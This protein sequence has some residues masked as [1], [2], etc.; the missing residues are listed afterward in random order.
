M[1]YDASIQMTKCQYY[2]V[3]TIIIAVNNKFYA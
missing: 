3:K 1:W 2:G